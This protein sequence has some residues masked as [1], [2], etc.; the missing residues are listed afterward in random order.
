M[1]WTCVTIELLRQDSNEQNNA[2]VACESQNDHFNIFFATFPN[3]VIHVCITFRLIPSTPRPPPFP[4]HLLSADKPRQKLLPGVIAC[5]IKDA[6]LYSLPF[7]F[8]LS[9]HYLSQTSPRQPSPWFNYRAIN[10]SAADSPPHHL[11]D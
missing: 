10:M 11:P 3:M 6:P 4:I 9:V 8:H 5:L 7:H 1:S 2:V